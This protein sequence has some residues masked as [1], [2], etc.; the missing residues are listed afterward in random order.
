MKRS[1]SRKARGSTVAAVNRDLAAEPIAQQQDF[2][3][4][5]FTAAELQRYLNAFGERGSE[6]LTEGK[7]FA[8]CEQLHNAEQ[9]ASLQGQLDSLKTS[10]AAELAAVK[11]DLAAAEHRIANVNLG[12]K[13][14]VSFSGEG[15]SAPNK[16]LGGGLPEGLQRFA[17]GIK[18]PGHGNP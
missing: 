7:P 15:Q 14:G 9:L 11:R 8:E 4:E 6:W 12:E 16:K 3:A 17:D 1:K 5:T 10:H 2:P 13:E 18:L